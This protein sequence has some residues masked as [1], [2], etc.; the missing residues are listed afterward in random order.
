M[1]SKD[2]PYESKDCAIPYVLQE[3]KIKQLFFK[4]KWYMTSK[5]TWTCMQAC[6]YGRSMVHFHL[7]K[8]YFS[9]WR[10]YFNLFICLSYVK[11]KVTAKKVGSYDQIHQSTSNA[12]KKGNGFTLS[13]MRIN[14]WGY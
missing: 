4:N 3:R 11:N 10:M 1:H 9:S 2:I 14:N 5:R 7:K 8:R 6:H 12:T 13:A